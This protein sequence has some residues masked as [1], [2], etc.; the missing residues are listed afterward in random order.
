M[1]YGVY[2][3]NPVKPDSTIGVIAPAYAPVPERLERG[4]R[5]LKDKG[6]RVAEGRSLAAKK[7]HF[8]GDDQLRL[9]DLHRMYADPEVDAIICARGGWGCLRYVDRID[10][11]LIRSNPKL[12]T[13]YS[14]ITTLQLAILKETGL[15]SL[16][17]PMVAVEM[18]L[19]IPAFTEKHF[20]NQIFNKE[21]QYSFNL[22]ENGADVFNSGRAEGI[23]QGGCLSLIAS[24]LG[25]PFQPGFKDA[26]L[27]IEDVG[28]SSY[29]IDRFLAQLKQSGI[30][31]SVRGVILGE[32]LDCDPEPG[33]MESSKINDLIHDYFGDLPVP[34]IYNFPYGHS[35]KKISIPL[36]VQ[37]TIDTDTGQVTFGNPFYKAG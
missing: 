8:A 19:G 17:G 35:L 13:G 37:A 9:D 29:K 26:V 36:G 20:F 12:L 3:L 11:D 18:G 30:L 24:Q 32:F 1:K 34:V 5:Y 31:Y 28:E 22:H 33:D 16:S 23:L 14:D 6:F 10:F 27:F 2:M 25:T 7:G 4:I 15:P 21:P